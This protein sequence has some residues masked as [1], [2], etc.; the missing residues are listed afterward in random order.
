MKDKKKG[1][2]I[3]HMFFVIS[4]IRFV[5][6]NLQM[7]CYTTDRQKMEAKLMP[8]TAIGQKN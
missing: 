3:V 2:L 8:G 6:T 7:I 1:W 5:K 4:Q